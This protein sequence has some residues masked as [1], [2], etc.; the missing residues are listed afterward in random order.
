VVQRI[1]DFVDPADF[2][3]TRYSKLNEVNKRFGRRYQIVG[4]RWLGPKE[5]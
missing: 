1:P 4:F 2:S 3:H 5:V